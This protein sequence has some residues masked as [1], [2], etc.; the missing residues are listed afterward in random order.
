MKLRHKRKQFW[1]TWRYTYGFD[2]GV[3]R[4]LHQLKDKT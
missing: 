3:A 2:W 1:W 4:I